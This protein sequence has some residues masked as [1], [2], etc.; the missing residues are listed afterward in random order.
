MSDSVK[1]WHEMQEE[2]LSSLKA[3]QEMAKQGIGQ[4]TIK[5]QIWQWNIIKEILYDY[6][7]EYDHRE[8]VRQVLIKINEQKL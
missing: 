6:L 8:D 4:E 2:K 3:D 5:I 7:D 1:K